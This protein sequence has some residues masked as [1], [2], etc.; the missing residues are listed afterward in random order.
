MGMTRLAV[1]TLL[2][3]FFAQRTGACSC[4]MQHPQ[5]QYCNSDFVILGRVRREQTYNSTY[6][7]IYKVN[8]RRKFK[9]SEKG[10][11][12]LKAGRVVT[13]L[14]GAMCG[15][16]LPLGKLYVISGRIVNLKPLFT[17]CD[18]VGEWRHFTKRQ[19]KGLR[20]LY[21][22]GCSCRISNCLYRSCRR[23]K[24]SCSWQNECEIQQGVCLRSSGDSCAW[25]KTKKLAACRREKRRPSAFVP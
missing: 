8:V 7:R 12:A 9:I 14:D 20:L 15:A 17:L 5:Q 6:M 24:D 10:E 16:G 11:V 22:R 3:L 2:V 1:A 25:G 18:L 13:P 21:E 4:M 23:H 19:Q